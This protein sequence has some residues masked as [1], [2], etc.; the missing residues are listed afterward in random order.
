VEGSFVFTELDS[1][2]LWIFFHKL[3]QSSGDQ[4]LIRSYFA[5]VDLVLH[6]LDETRK[7]LGLIAAGKIV[8]EVCL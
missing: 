4:D 1:I 8:V 5:H 3:K 7:R 2:E 6:A